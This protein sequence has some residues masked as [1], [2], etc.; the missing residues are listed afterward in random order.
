MTR[1]PITDE[2]DF[3]DAL[4]GLGG[5]SEGAVTDVLAAWNRSSVRTE[6]AQEFA[7][8]IVRV[9]QAAIDLGNDP[10]T[11]L[12][13]IKNS[14]IRSFESKTALEMV[15]EG[16]TDDVVAYLQS[17]SAGTSANERPC[18]AGAIRDNSWLQSQV[19]G[20]TGTGTL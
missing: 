17:L 3:I 5:K 6:R 4:A 18:E 14:P 8:N 10:T 7:R 11:A 9:L 2:Q 1:A 16:R 19:M 20:G 15:E 12:R 13:N